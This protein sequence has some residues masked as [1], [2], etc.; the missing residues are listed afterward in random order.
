[1]VGTIEHGRL[2]PQQRI[3]GDHAV[4]HLFLDALLDGRDEFAGD[5]PADDLVGEL[6]PFLAFVR[7]GEADPAMAVLAAAAGLAD[8]LA[9]DLAG[10]ADRLAVGHLGLAGVALDAEL[11]LHAV[12][13]DVQVQLAHAGDDGLAG[14]LVGLDAERRVFLGQLAQGDAHLFLV[15]LGLRL[16]RHRDHRVGEVHAFEDDRLVDGAQGVAGG[17]VLHADQRGDVTGAHFLDLGAVVGMHLH[18]AADALLLALHRVEHGIAG[19][20]HAGVD[21]DEGQGADEGV[22]GDLEGQRGEGFAVV[23]VAFVLLL[24]VIRVGAADGGNLGGCREQFD[25]RVQHQRHALVLEGRA[26][27]RRHH[28]AGQ[29][30]D[31]QAG[32][33]LFLGEVAFVEVFR[34]QLFVGLG[35]HFQHHVAPVPGLVQLLGGY[36]LLAG[37]G[38]LVGVVPVDG[39]HADQVD[40]AMEV[41]LLANGQ[42]DGHRSVAEALLDLLHHPQEVGAGAVHLVHVGDARHVVLVGLAPDGLGLRLHAI[43]AAEHHHRAIQHAQGTLHLDGE[44]DVAGGVDDVDAEFLQLLARAGPEGGGGR[45][46]DGD[47]ALLLLDHPVHGRGAVVH[48]AHLVVDPGVVEDPLGGGGLAGIHVGHYADVAVMADG[49]CTGHGN[50][51]RAGLWDLAGPHALRRYQAAPN[52]NWKVVGGERPGGPAVR[53]WHGRWPAPPPFPNASIAIARAPA[54]HPLVRPDDALPGSA[55][56][57]LLPG[58]IPAAITAS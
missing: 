53:A 26:A 12:D 10:L 55:L 30:A 13:D 40:L 56:H 22:G 37:R 34:H 47:A 15:G 50:H 49:G 8:E 35:R 43:G 52:R 46:G 33:D 23:G 18:H 57:V 54:A 14:F 24:R 38:A 44:I 6:Q 2:Q 1:M 48:L 19:V 5:D 21:A 27:H 29:G 7:R 32:L 4:L 25:H 42:L 17:D 28:F 20:Q 3:A 51:L 45:R 39:L 9:L 36:L 31:A 41:L 16:H 58:R 11:A